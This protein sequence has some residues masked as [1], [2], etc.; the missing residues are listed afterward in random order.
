MSGD[1]DFD[2]AADVA[3]KS[4]AVHVEKL[5]RQTREGGIGS[6]AYNA[7][8]GAR[9]RFHEEL[10]PLVVGLK[11]LPRGATVIIVARKMF[12][13]AKLTAALKVLRALARKL[14]RDLKFVGVALGKAVNASS[15][16]RP[17][18]ALAPCVHRDLMKAVT[19]E[20]ELCG[21][22]ATASSPR[23]GLVYTSSESKVLK[24]AYA[25]SASTRTTSSDVEGLELV[26]ACQKRDALR[27]RVSALNLLRQRILEHEDELRA[28]NKA[29]SAFNQFYH[30]YRP[31]LKSN[32]DSTHRFRST[33]VL[34]R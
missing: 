23:W 15:G 10:A 34:K 21:N 6:P 11:D 13:G 17:A 12:S 3:R 7:S 28:G 20:L 29:C 14:K 8:P 22:Q 16:A 4:G 18:E 1:P 32:N 25:G 19:K 24:G 9:F 33:Q 27:A 31:A 26:D 5:L 30:E 2:L